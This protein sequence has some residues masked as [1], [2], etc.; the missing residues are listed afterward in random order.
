MF[1]KIWRVFLI[2]EFL[3]SLVVFGPLIMPFFT[4]I[5]GID[6]VKIMTLQSTYQLTTMFMEVP[7]GALGDKYGRKISVILGN[8]FYAFGAFLYS[9]I[10]GFSTLLIAEFLMGIGTAFVSGAF[11][12]LV[13]DTFKEYKKEKEYFKYLTVSG[14]IN[15]FGFLIASLLATVFALFSSGNVLAFSVFGMFIT[16]NLPALPL[17][18]FSFLVYG[19]FLILADLLLLLYIKEPKLSKE[20]LIPDYKKI[21]FKSIKIFKDNK[22]LAGLGGLFI[23]LT[24]LSYYKFWIGQRFLKLIGISAVWFGVMRFIDGV[25]GIVI[26]HY[27]PKIRDYLGTRNMFRLSAGLETLLF[28]VFLGATWQGVIKNDANMAMQDIL[29]ILVPF[30]GIVAMSKFTKPVV[31]DLIQ[32]HVPSNIRATVLSFLGL[33]GNLIRGGFNPVIGYL[34]DLNIRFVL[35]IIILFSITTNLFVGFWA[36]VKTGVVGK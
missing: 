31:R 29:L 20:E 6:M 7:T 12:A 13:Y 27:L 17:V 32:Q 35:Y 11:S 24:T 30:I 5:A 34:A 36:K 14:K 22:I 28:L 10:P 33:G 23:V 1:R 9:L 16:I 15:S 8:L 25:L 2:Y 19:I 21:V 18:R 4:D 26:N 3:T